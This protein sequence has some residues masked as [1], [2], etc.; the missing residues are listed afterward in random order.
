MTAIMFFY[1]KGRQLW[2]PLDDFQI[3]TILFFFWFPY[4]PDFAS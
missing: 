3:F 1:N 4:F 2:Q